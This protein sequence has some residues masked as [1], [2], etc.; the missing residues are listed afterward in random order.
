VAQVPKLPSCCVHSTKNSLSCKSCH[1]SY[2][3]ECLT[4]CGTPDCKGAR[5]CP[6]CQHHNA[7]IKHETAL[8]KD[9]RRRQSQTC[10]EAQ[11]ETTQ[12]TH[13][14]S[15]SYSTEALISLVH[16][17][18]LWPSR[19]RMNAR[20]TAQRRVCAR[21]NGIPFSPLSSAPRNSTLE[22]RTNASQ[23]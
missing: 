17:F 5:S 19:K 3:A 4:D 6:L 18:S 7:A 13:D 15:I 22:H 14:S 10:S 2:H 1:L 8:V 16:S 20:R 12:T 23:N 11:T 9:F 21:Y